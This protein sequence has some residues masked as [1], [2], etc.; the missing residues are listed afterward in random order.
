PEAARALGGRAKEYVAAECNWNVVAKRYAA[1]LEAV[2]RGEEWREP[3][4]AAAVAEEP[5]IPSEE[6][7]PY[8]HTWAHNAQEKWY[9]D[10][11]ET[12][13]AKT[14]EITPPGGPGKSVL[15]MGAYM[16]IT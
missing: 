13:L 9:I 3:A 6:A 11:H 2:A 5:A 16:Q 10:T 14:L 4:S 15:E 12:R 7:K 8:L 1:F